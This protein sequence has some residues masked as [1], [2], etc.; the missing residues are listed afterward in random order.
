MTSASE[1]TSEESERYASGKRCACQFSEVNNESGCDNRRIKYPARQESVA[2]T[3][4][5]YSDLYTD[6]LPVKVK[7][8]A[9]LEGTS[10]LCSLTTVWE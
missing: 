8:V 7:G 1:W 5:P 9:P 10:P 2:A 4:R 3:F 6:P